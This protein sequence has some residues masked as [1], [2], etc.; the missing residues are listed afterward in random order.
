MRVDDVDDE[1][2]TLMGLLFE[3]AAGAGEVLEASFTPGTEICGQLFEP[4]LRLVRTDGGRLRM[5]DLAAQCRYNVSTLTRVA[6]RLAG[7]G[8][9]E[10]QVCES[11]RR[12]TYLAITDAGREAMRAEVPAHVDVIRTSVFGVLDPEE[13]RQLAALLE[14]V[15]DAVHPGATDGVVR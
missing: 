15:R 11:D 3:V 4:L 8:F 12:V 2:I 13:Q 14:R 5:T 6:D 7:L 9:A 10:R 1:S